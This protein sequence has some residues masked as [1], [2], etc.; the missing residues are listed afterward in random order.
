MAEGRA[1]SRMGK[2]LGRSLTHYGVG[3]DEVLRRERAREGRRMVQGRAPRMGKDLG[4]SAGRKTCAARRPAKAWSRSGSAPSPRPRFEERGARPSERRVLARATT[5]VQKDFDRLA[6]MRGLLG[7]GVSQ[8]LAGLTTT[9]SMIP[10]SLA[11]TFVA[12]VPPIVGLHAAAT[13]AFFTAIFGSQ[14]GVISGAAGAT[15]VVLAPL[16]A[17]F[18]IEYLFAA[19]VLSGLIQLGF[20]ALRFGKFI[21]LVPQPVMMGFVNGLAI[22]IGVSQLEQFK[23]LSASGEHVWMQGSQL[24]IMAA[25]TAVTMLIIRFWPKKMK[26]LSK[27]P[28]PLAAILTVTASVNLLH[29]HTRTVGDMASIAGSLPGLHI[30]QVPLTLGT[31]SV[32]APTALA[33]AMVGLIETLLTQQL[34]DQIT[35]KGPSSTHVECIA[36]GVGNVMTGFLGGMGGC[37]MIGQSMI[38][39][40]SGG[41]HRLSGLSCAFFLAMSV[42]AGSSLIEKIPLAALVGTMWMLVIDIFDKSTFKRL[43]KVPKTDSLV[44][45]LVT[46]VTVFTNLAVAVVAGVVVSSLNFAWKSAQRITSS[47]EVEPNAAYGKAAAVFKLQGPLFFGSVTQFRE[48]FSAQKSKSESEE[49]VVLDFM[50]SRVWDSSALEA[51]SEVVQTYQNSNKE[52]HIRHLSRDCQKLLTNAGDLYDLNVIE[53]DE[54]DPSYGVAANYDGE[55]LASQSPKSTGMESEGESEADRMN[56]AIMRQYSGGRPEETDPIQVPAAAEEELR[57]VGETTTSPATTAGETAASARDPNDAW[58]SW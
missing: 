38:N 28:A 43:S 57:W 52:I 26:F 25:L 11:F 2:D 30:P 12:G 17:K 33:V 32:I 14:H 45:A 44:V 41:R 55:V 58:Y 4:R 53:A 40:N 34:V 22:V 29:I 1:A 24:Y 51:I 48:M 15:A 46:G 21:R 27:V 50:E 7:V 54:D 36:Q 9:L 16:C 39:V 19:V 49:V 56:R 8:I 13:M 18:G 37:A 23:V 31:L 5:E 10:E 42:I 20:G 47:R 6:E 3:L 35:E